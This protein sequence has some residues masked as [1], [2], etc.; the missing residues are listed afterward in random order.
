MA[1]DSR[2]LCYCGAKEICGAIKE[3]PRQIQAL[4][5]HEGLPVFR[6]GP[7]CK[8]RALPADLGKWLIGQRDKYTK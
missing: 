8:Y 5:E 6:R 1:G 2:P 4:I 7:K 3:D